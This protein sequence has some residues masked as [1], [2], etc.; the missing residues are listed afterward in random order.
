MTRFVIS[1][2]V[3]R[4][5]FVN[6]GDGSDTLIGRGGPDRL[7]GGSGIDDVRGGRGIDVVGG[8]LLAGATTLS[9]TEL[10]NGGETDTLSSIERAV[11]TVVGP[12]Y[13]GSAFDGPQVIQA[14]NAVAATAGPKNDT[15]VFAGG[16]SGSFDGGPGSDT[17]E[18]QAS[19]AVN[20]DPGQVTSGGGTYTLA[21]IERGYVIWQANAPSGGTVDARDWVKPLRYENWSPRKVTLLGGHA[22]DRATGGSGRDI[23]KGFDGDDTL[24]GKGGKDS[25]IGG[26]GR[27]V[28]KG[29]PGADSVRGCEA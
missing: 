24:L 21:S 8:F 16:H 7:T 29:G 14:G 23:L 22:T 17:V 19:T 12:T 3:R 13:D 10:V 15:M 5:P 27:D 28:C 9:N 4:R 1:D 11:L 2:F 6:A 18:V 20:L 25:L 26:R